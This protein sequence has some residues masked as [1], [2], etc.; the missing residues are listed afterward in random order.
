MKASRIIF[1]A[2]F[3]ATMTL[4]LN[5]LATVED[6]FENDDG[7]ENARK[8]II[9][10]E[11]PQARNFHR[12]DDQDWIKFYAFKEN[13]YNIKAVN[14][15]TGNLMLELYDAADISKE[16][17]IQDTPLDPQ[18]NEILTT[19]NAL[20]HDGV[21]YVKVSLSDQS[22]FSDNA[23]YDLTA[24]VPEAGEPGKIYGAV[25]D[26]VNGDFIGDAIVTTDPQL[27][28]DISD[29]NDGT[30]QLLDH[31]PGDFVM[32]ARRSADDAM[33][34]QTYLTC[35]FEDR[36]SDNGIRKINI[37][38]IPLELPGAV[39]ILQ[40]ISGHS[41]NHLVSW[42]QDIDGNKQLGLAEVVYILRNA[43]GLP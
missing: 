10:E 2:V 40:I 38:M 39:L 3:F 29:P 21:Y 41:Q 35:M 6:G 14:K 13:V 37:G 1:F 5:G 34:N 31:Q 25:S 32:T 12:A 30:Y 8:I 42:Q 33:E 28:S 36:L 17:K 23:S 18:A 27:A 11:T 15:G 24:Y 16:I 20:P 26:A 7:H 4:T 22:T 9:N 19:R 43:A